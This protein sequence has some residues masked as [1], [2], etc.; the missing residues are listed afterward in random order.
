MQPS[1][2]PEVLTIKAIDVLLQILAVI[3]S[4]TRE[5][6]SQIFNV[7]QPFIATLKGVSSML[8]VGG[9]DVNVDRKRLAEEGANILVGTPGKLNDI[10][11][12]ED[13]LDYK[14]FEVVSEMM[15]ACV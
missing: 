10:M 9:V 5:L 11:Q 14:N 13:T 15:K 4:P 12:N 8:F 7:A 3:V 6:S 2:T 1:L